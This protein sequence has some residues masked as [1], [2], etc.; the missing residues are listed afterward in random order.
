[1]ANSSGEEDRPL[2]ISDEIL[3]DYERTTRRNPDNQQTTP[4]Q[5]RDSEPM[6]VSTS[7]M[8][9]PTTQ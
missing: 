8:V 6:A 1:M 3:L 7:S 9:V 2:I 5:V 4:A